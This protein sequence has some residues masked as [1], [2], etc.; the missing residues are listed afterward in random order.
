MKNHVNTGAGKASDPAKYYKDEPVSGME[1]EELLSMARLKML[2]EQPFFG[3][4][5]YSMVIIENNSIP[6][7]AVDPRGRLFYNRKWV[8]GMTLEDAI[9]EFGH[10]TMHIVQRCFDR[11]PEGGDPGMWNKAADWRCD[12]DLVDAGF[13]QSEISKEA[14]TSE[15]QEKTRKLG[16]IE[17]IYKDML[18]NAENNTQCEACKQFLKQLQG[19]SEKEKQEAAAENKA[20]NGK[21][22]EEGEGGEEGESGAPGEGCGGEGKP[23]EHT[24][25][26]VRH[27]CTGQTADLSKA[28]PMDAQKWLETIVAAKMHAEGK[29]NMP[30]ALGEAIDELT[31]STVRWQDYLKTHATKIFGKDLYTYKRYNRRGHA[32]GVRMP[33]CRPD[34]KTAVIA[35]DTS[36]SMSEEDVRQCVTEAASIMVACGAVKVWLILHDMRAYYSGYVSDADLT[37]LKMSRGGTSHHEVFDILRRQ[38]DDELKNVPRDEDVSLAILFT[39][40]GTDF[41]DY[42]PDFEVIWGV[43]VGGCPGIDA[44]VPFG[45][46]VPVELG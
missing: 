37:K 27:C 36:G 1:A 22:G 38:H 23:L 32:I 12:T 18:V 42:R 2:M 11:F 13:T 16:T 34:G 19:M 30:G 4:I 21:D 26:N 28:D 39:D 44:N 41:P 46:K 35:I 25:G 33:A 10:E 6:T 5:A 8:N 3:K 20:L 15:T 29:G 45:L 14:V 7:T 40:L 17:A 31:K 43:P 24:C 9:F